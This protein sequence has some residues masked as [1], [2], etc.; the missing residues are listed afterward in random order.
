MVRDELIPCTEHWHGFD[1]RSYTVIEMAIRR[2]AKDEN[3]CMSEKAAMRRAFDHARAQG[4]LKNDDF[5]Y[6]NFGQPVPMLDMV[7]HMRNELMHGTPHLY[8]NCSLTNMEL[9]FDLIVTLFS[10]EAAKSP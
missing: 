6:T 4:W 2:R 9:A 3:S 10:P 5:G 1:E 7:V 8:P